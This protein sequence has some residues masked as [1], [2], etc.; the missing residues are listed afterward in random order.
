MH[1]NDFHPT[2]NITIDGCDVFFPT[3][4]RIVRVGPD[5]IGFDAAPKLD[6]NWL[7]VVNLNTQVTPGHFWVVF[8]LDNGAD[9]HTRSERFR[10]KAG[11]VRDY[12][13]SGFR[14]VVS[15]IGSNFNLQQ[16]LDAF[17]Q[18]EKHLAKLKRESDR[19]PNSTPCYSFVRRPLV[20][21]SVE[22]EAPL[23]MASCENTS[24]ER[25]VADDA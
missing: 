25:L 15:P 3:T 24:H 21:L 16:V 14:I 13:L 18:R 2:T 10:L 7:N 4:F 11:D 5:L 17:Q 19:Y 20:T 22:S 23:V 12:F 1:A 9:A 6:V 8:E